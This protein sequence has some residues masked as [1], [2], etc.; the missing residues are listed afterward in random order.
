MAM[1]VALLVSMGVCMRCWLYIDTYQTLL[2]L[3]LIELPGRCTT[4]C[5]S[6]LFIC[7][8]TMYLKK[9]CEPIL[10]NLLQSWAGVMFFFISHFS[11]QSL[12]PFILFD[13]ALDSCRC[14]G[15]SSRG[16]WRSCP[17]KQ[18]NK[19]SC[20]YIVPLKSFVSSKPVT[21]VTLT[22]SHTGRSAVHSVEPI[23][24]HSHTDGITFGTR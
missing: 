1:S 19:W 21:F 12:D 13:F 24:T 10:M 9:A 6:C 14:V 2:S 8:S 22:H 3:W 4:L 5:T 17:G 20:I 15:G 11:S 23:Q 18:W 7:G 16:G